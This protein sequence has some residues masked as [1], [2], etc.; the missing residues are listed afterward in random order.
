M[1]KH[2]QV[3][4]VL[5]VIG[6]GGG[7]TLTLTQIQVA[8]ASSSSTAPNPYCD[9]VPDDYQGSCHDRMDYDQETGQ[10][11]CNDG[12]QNVRWQDCPDASKK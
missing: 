8:E 1:L 6:I 3:L 2:L 7:L 9:L 10:Y 12:T 11:P 5:A 4:T